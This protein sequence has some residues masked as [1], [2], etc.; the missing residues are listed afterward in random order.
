VAPRDEALLPRLQGLTAEHPLWEDQS[1]WAP[2][3][4]VAPL[5]VQKQ[6][7]RWVRREPKRRGKPHLKYRVK[8]TP[9][10]STPRPPSPHEG[11][12]ST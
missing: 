6:R 10:W 4:V 7:L 5:P 1:I 12:V 9:L 2:L 8:R 11:G 3:P